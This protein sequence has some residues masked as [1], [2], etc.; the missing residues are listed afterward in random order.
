[1]QINMY[2]LYLHFL[3]FA[4]KNRIFKIVSQIFAAIKEY[5]DKVLNLIVSEFS[6][7]RSFKT[8]FYIPRYFNPCNGEMKSEKMCAFKV[9]FK[10]FEN[11][12][13]GKYLFRF[14][15]I[16]HLWIKFENISAS[17]DYS[18]TNNANDN[19]YWLNNTCRNHCTNNTDTHNNCYH[20]RGSVL[21]SGSELKYISIQDSNKYKHFLNLLL[22]F[23]I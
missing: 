1:M 8:C 9:L 16:Q 14:V 5:I 19:Y 15:I 18:E 3:F 6:L 17:F 10:K 23:H 20:H 2:T 4:L 22:Y 7:K 11:I 21:F 12:F 13:T